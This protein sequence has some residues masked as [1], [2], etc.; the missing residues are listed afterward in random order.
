MNFYVYIYYWQDEPFYVGMGK[1][2]RDISHLTAIQKGKSLKNLHLG[3]TISKILAANQEVR[4][5]RVKEYLTEVEAKTLEVKL[6]ALYGRRDLNK[7]PLTNMTDGGDGYV[8]WSDDA[9]NRASARKR[10]T[11]VVKDGGGKVFATSIKDPRLLSGEL[12]GQNKGR[13]TANGSMKNLVMARL[14]NGD[15]ARIK[16]ADYQKNGAV[17]INYGK[18]MCEEQ[19]G[20]ISQTLKNNP[21]AGAP[22]KSCTLDGIVIFASYSAMARALGRGKT[23]T[24][25]PNFRYI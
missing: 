19:K 21:N 13:K 4:I 2:K 22:K 23:G 14:P 6:V 12:V 24:R 8:N 18:V 9:K 3:N 17:G 7:G 16:Y 11:T 25:H 10:G 20:K 5:V 1:N 15:V